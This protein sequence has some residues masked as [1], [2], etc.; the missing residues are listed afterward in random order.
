MR[1]ASIALLE[2]WEETWLVSIFYLKVEAN[3]D[4]AVSDADNTIN[5]SHTEAS[6]QA[7]ER[8]QR[9]TLDEWNFLIELSEW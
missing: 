1:Q 6:G 3:L 7:R 9:N 2:V 8:S 5:R 4:I